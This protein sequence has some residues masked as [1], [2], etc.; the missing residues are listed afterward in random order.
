MCRPAAPTNWAGL[1]ATILP[2][3]PAGSRLCTVDVAMQARQA[4]T[5]L[6][7]PGTVSSGRHNAVHKI[8]SRCASHPTLCRCITTTATLPTSPKRI[9]P[10]PDVFIQRRPMVSGPAPRMH[11]KLLGPRRI[12]ARLHSL[13]PPRFESNTK[14]LPNCGL[15][16]RALTV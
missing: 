7:R 11:S 12:F 1:A 5:N 3:S 6:R 4:Q 14:H 2:R 9:P 8:P 13:V 10:S 15:P 16:C